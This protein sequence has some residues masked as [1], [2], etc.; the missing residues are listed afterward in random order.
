MQIHTSLHSPL[1]IQSSAV[2]VGTFDGMHKGHAEIIDCIKSVAHQQNNAS[3]V[4]TFDRHPRLVLGNNQDLKILTSRDEKICLFATAGID[5]LVVL[6]FTQEFSLMSADDFVRDILLQKIK[7]KHLVMGR[8]HQFGRREA[9]SHN[10]VFELSK[11]YQFGCTEV[12]EKW[13]EGKDVS[14]THIRNLLIQGK[15][16]ESESLLGYPYFI[17]GT[18]IHG[19]KRG[20][21]LGYPTANLLPDTEDKLLPMP[22]V[23][24][25]IAEVR[26]RY[27]HGM[28]SIGN[29]PTFNGKK[30]SIE[31]HLLDFSEN[32]YDETLRIYFV[33]RI[34]S[35][36]KFS[37][38]EELINK[39]KQDE[40]E[41]RF[42][43][44]SIPPFKPFLPCPV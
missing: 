15:I 37:G 40:K 9:G 38:A 43:F 6:P 42:L 10:Q 28:L 44:S 29:R 2:C 11:K 33:Q 31:T 3:V 26:K 14:S 18:V 23:Y 4:L 36:E 32:I 41:V 22:G 19:E 30:I 1:N 8:E 17:T 13:V 5:Q 35:E 27:Y 25:V 16:E 21:N 34:R 12:Q 7:M 24:A 20:R 39:M